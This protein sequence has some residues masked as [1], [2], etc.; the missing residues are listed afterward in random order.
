[1]KDLHVDLKTKQKKHT[2]I[3]QMLITYTRNHS[4]SNSSILIENIRISCY[5]LLTN[6]NDPCYKY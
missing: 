3:I 5:E 2:K 6:Q 4:F 1:M